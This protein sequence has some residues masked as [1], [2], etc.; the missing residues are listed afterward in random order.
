MTCTYEMWDGAYVLGSLSPAERREFEE[1]LDTC[2]ECSRAVRDLAG[3]PGLLGR[4]GPEVLEAGPAEPVPETLRPRLFRAVRRQ[5]AR[6]TWLT[7]GIAAAAAAA[8][9][10]G[11]A[12][13]LDRGQPSTP[14]SGNHPTTVIST[15][16]PQVMTA[17]SHNPMTAQVSLTP[18]AWG[19]RLDLT[20]TYPRSWGLYEGGG[21]YALVVHTGN[22]RSHQVATWRGLPGRAMRLTAS[23][24]APTSTIRS[25]D[26]TTSEGKPVLRLQL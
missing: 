26:I 21:R 19:T 2:E 7:A 25:V 8:I 13:A 14:T 6:R 5:R 16:P 22:G 4:I 10:I 20:C 17:V 24:A 11:A 23:T 9:T 3:L 18:V 15:A 12:A 1:H